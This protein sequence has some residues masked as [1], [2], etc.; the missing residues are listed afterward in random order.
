[1][2]KRTKVNISIYKTNNYDMFK[3]IASNRV[4]TEN[5]VK[6]IMSEI[7]ANNFLEENPVK[8]NKNHEIIEGQHT[9][10]ACVRL[11]IPVYYMYTKMTK[12]NIGRFNSS[13]KTWNMEDVLHHYC[14]EGVHDYKVLAG[15]RSRHPYPLS[16]LIYLLTGENSK[17]VLTEYRKGE[18]KIG[19]SLDT[20]EKLLDCIKEFK[21]YS[22]KIYRNR[23]FI[24]SYIDVLT[25]PD[26]KHDVFVHK[27]S[28]APSKFTKQENKRDYFRMIE[29][30]YNFKNNNPIRLF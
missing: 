18:F 5:H 4:I 30:V 10:Q 28:L 17:R 25:H 12:K 1:M 29:D 13:R 27:V 26:F 9:F 20:V 15:F 16:T 24:T 2:N 22:D 21:E 19:Q 6:E 8:V 3:Y 14:V 7:Q 11:E 23:A